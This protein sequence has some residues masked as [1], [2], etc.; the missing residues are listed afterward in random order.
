MRICV[1][2]NFR[3]DNIGDDQISFP[4]TLIFGM[5][6]REIARFRQQFAI[7]I[8]RRYFG[9]AK[10]VYGD[11]VV[12]EEE[13]AMVFQRKKLFGKVRAGIVEG[14]NIVEVDAQRV[15]RAHR[16]FVF[17]WILREWKEVRMISR[18]EMKQKASDFSQR[19]ILM[20][21]W[22]GFP[23]G[24]KQIRESTQWRDFT[25]RMLDKAR[26]YLAI[27]RTETLPQEATDESSSL[28]G[29]FFERV[30]KCLLF[31]TAC[32]ECSI[33]TSRNPLVQLMCCRCFQCHV[34]GPG[35]HRTKMRP[36][37][38]VISDM[39]ISGVFLQYR[40]RHPPLSGNRSFDVR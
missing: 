8:Q 7:A 10:Q 23:M 22:K 12:Q 38:L 11:R 32:E 40:H 26:E 29:S 17:K 9:M 3:D 30:D 21:A 4:L 1:D 18:M 28:D 27:N 33:N 35:H 24:L 2:L 34:H 15:A 13:K 39:S 20:K 25:K 16:R 36:D 37:F 6:E 19:R 5:R 31:R 14:R